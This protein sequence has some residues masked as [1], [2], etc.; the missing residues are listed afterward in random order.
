MNPTTNWN[1]IDTVLLDM[2]GTI[3]DL[4]FDN[5]FWQEYMPEVFA[6][7]N[8][9]SLVESSQFLSES[10]GELK[11]KLQWYCLDFWSD[12][13]DLD[14]PALKKEL[15][16]MVAFR[17]GAVEFLKFLSDKKKSVCLATNAHRKTLEIKMLNADFNQYFGELTSSH[18]FGYP[19][20]EQE[21]WHRLKEKFP[22]DPERTLFID[23]SVTILESAKRFGIKYLYGISEPDSRKGPVDA[24]PFESISDFQEWIANEK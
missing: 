22:F 16:H 3:L 6:K 7:K 5:F 12:K 19:K 14:I 9:M 2:D 4:A 13:L 21:Y 8:A 10:Y 20:E 17:P 11:G 1:E 23:D 24:S 15:G 18:D